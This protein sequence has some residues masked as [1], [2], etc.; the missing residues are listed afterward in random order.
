MPFHCMSMMGGNSP[1]REG[2][3]SGGMSGEC[4]GMSGAKCPTPERV[5]PG[6]TFLFLRSKSIFMSVQAV[7]VLADEADRPL[8][9]WIKAGLS[10]PC[11][12]VGL[13]SSLSCLT[14]STV[15]LE[16]FFSRNESPPSVKIFSRV[17]DSDAGD[18]RSLSFGSLPLRVSVYKQ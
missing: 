9:T 16:P 7:L 2:K 6:T 3:M 5:T 4:R 17:G 8:L 15:N 18:S 13:V 11:C 1:T 12:D 10:K 14:R